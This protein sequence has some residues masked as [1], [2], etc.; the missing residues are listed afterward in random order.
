MPTWSGRTEDEEPDMALR[1]HQIGKGTLGYKGETAEYYESKRGLWDRARWVIAAVCLLLGAAFL[2]ASASPVVPT[3][4]ASVT[5]DGVSGTNSVVLVAPDGATATVTMPYAD[6]PAVGSTQQAMQLPGGRLILGDP[7]A[8]GRG[9]AVVLIAL[10]LGIIARAWWRI[11]HP[12]PLPTT[13]IVPDDTY[14]RPPH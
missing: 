11:R 10:G 9:A 2:V 1:E 4:V 13:V 8:Q 14:A 6:T 5:D 3:R 12:R 7:S